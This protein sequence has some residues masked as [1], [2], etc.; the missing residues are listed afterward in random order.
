MYYIHIEE[1]IEML[2][3]LTSIEEI[4][5]FFEEVMN[6]PHGKFGLAQIYGMAY[7]MQEINNKKKE[8]EEKINLS[9]G[10]RIVETHLIGED[11]AIVHVAKTKGEEENYYYVFV[12]KEEHWKRHF[13]VAEHFDVALIM[14]ICV[15]YADGHFTEAVYNMLRMDKVLE[16]S[17]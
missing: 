9:P 8:I 5:K 6:K 16:T 14:A 15:K 2:Q 11:I 4:L 7:N 3:R 10:M 13:E 12:K 1:E 17:S